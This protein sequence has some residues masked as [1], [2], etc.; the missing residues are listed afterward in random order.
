MDT[1][2]KIHKEKASALR[3][4]KGEPPSMY[5]IMESDLSHIKC[6]PMCSSRDTVA[7]AEVY[8]A[9]KL[10]FFRTSACAKCLFTYRSIYPS[11]AWFE[12]CWRQIDEKVFKKE[13]GVFNP[14]G[15]Q[16][17]KERYEEYFGMLKKFGKGTLLDI[18]AAWGTGTNVF[19]EQGYTVHAIEPEAGKRNH[20]EKGGIPV[21][22]SSIEEFLSGP[23]EPYDFVIFAHCLEHIEN[24][25]FAINH[26]GKAVKPNG[27]VYLEIPILWQY[28]NW[29]DALY[30]LHKSNFTEE[31]ILDLVRQSG[32]EVIDT[33]WLYKHS[34]DMPDFGTIL[35]YTGKKRSGMTPPTHTLDDIYAAYRKDL[36]QNPPD[37]VLKYSVP[38][39][40][41]AA[42]VIIAEGKTM[43]MKNGFITFVPQ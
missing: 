13:G 24:P 34:K 16:V 6:C 23:V 38:V 20:L 42:Q 36:L 41:H 29:S 33:A 31:N 21:V 9:E 17:R 2:L 7:I 19:K 15:E 32:F 25:V 14:E 1:F 22:G 35:H 43:V 40:E 39:I 30:L 12:K 37:G 4:G 3:H 5:P 18:G 26:L 11:L 28:V 27:I 8:L 10:C